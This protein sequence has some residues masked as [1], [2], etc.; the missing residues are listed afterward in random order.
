[1]T[2]TVRNAI[3]RGKALMAIEHFFDEVRDLLYIDPESTQA[4]ATGD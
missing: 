1:V 4:A 2:V 3:I